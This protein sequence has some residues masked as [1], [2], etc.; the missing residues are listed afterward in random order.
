MDSNEFP[1]NSRASKGG[2]PEDR[3]ITPVATGAVRRK[4]SLRKQF[5]ET[6]I[7]GDF[8]STVNRLHD[9]G[10]TALW[11]AL[12]LANDQLTEYALKY[13]NAKKRILCISDGLDTKSNRRPADLCQALVHNET[14]V[15]SFCLG[16]EDN[17]DLRAIS[18]LTSGYKFAPKSLEQAMSICEMEPVLAQMERDHEQIKSERETKLPKREPGDSLR[19]F[20]VATWYATPEIVTKDVFPKRKEHPNLKDQFI[21]LLAV[22]RRVLSAADRSDSNFRNTRLLTEAQNAAAKPHPHYDI[23]VSERDMSFWKIV[24]QGPPES[25]YSSG[26]FVLYLHMEENYPIFAPKGRFITPIYHPN[27]NRHGRICHSIFD[28]NWTSDTSNAMI[29][30]TIYGLLFEP[31]YSDPV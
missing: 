24:M 14:I 12:A 26:T 2:R 17:Q 3:K 8:R 4:R 9:E 22:S 23:Y 21:E 1:P 20:T 19:R 31:D 30:S 7:G 27:I 15:D 13:P 29:L 18:Y 28:R 10:D 5:S 11:D 16:N 25:I 6:F